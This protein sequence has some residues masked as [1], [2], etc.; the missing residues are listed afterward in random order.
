M[1]LRGLARFGEILQLDIAGALH[2]A[3]ERVLAPHGRA[4][5]KA[6][7]AHCHFATSLR[8]AAIRCWLELLFISAASIA[9]NSSFGPMPRKAAVRLSRPRRSLSGGRYSGTT[10]T[11]PLNQFVLAFLGITSSEHLV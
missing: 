10:E 6:P 2:S 5:L 7:G 9:S 8:F 4:L 11:D 1:D 3:P